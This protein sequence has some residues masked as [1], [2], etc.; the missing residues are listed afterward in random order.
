MTQTLTTPDSETSSHSEKTIHEILLGPTE[1]GGA[2][3]LRAGTAFNYEGESHFVLRLYMF[4]RQTY[5]L[6]KNRNSDVGYTI[7][8]HRVF[9]AT[10]EAGVKFQN[11]VGSGRLGEA[12]KS[13]LE[14]RMPL[15]ARSLFMDLYPIK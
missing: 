13:H 3:N 5:Y 4:P 6:V 2:L 7:F 15:L 11:P 8:G 9:D 10:S 12:S 14:I 1:T